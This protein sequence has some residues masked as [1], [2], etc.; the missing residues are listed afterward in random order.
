MLWAKPRDPLAPEI[1]AAPP[2]SESAPGAQAGWRFAKSAGAHLA[3][4]AV[5]SV[6]LTAAQ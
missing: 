6:V 1:R 5:L 4:L 3:R 2:D